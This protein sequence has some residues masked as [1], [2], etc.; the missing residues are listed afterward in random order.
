MSQ[1]H[2]I[3][4][5][6][7]LECGSFGTQ[8]VEINDIKIIAPYLLLVNSVREVKLEI[9]IAENKSIEELKE[10]LIIFDKQEDAGGIY[11]ESLHEGNST[12]K[13]HFSNEFVYDPLA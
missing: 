8:M 2:Y 5:P 12:V 13:K 7:E 4:S 10:E 6:V 11:I 3:A 1:F 9:P